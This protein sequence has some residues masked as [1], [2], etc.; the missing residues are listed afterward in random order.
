MEPFDTSKYELQRKPDG[1]LVRLEINQ[2]TRETYEAPEMSVEDYD[3]RIK[4][5]QDEIT[6]Q[7][8]IISNLEAQKAKVVEFVRENPKPVVEGQSA[9]LS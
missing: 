9:M 7:Q 4:Q 8:T 5:A 1:T 6:K 3:A 2:F